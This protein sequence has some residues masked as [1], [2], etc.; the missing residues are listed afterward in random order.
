MCKII[1]KK[2]LYLAQYIGF[3]K[4]SIGKHHYSPHVANGSDNAELNHQMGSYF[5]YYR[6]LEEK[7]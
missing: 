7:N 6:H 2:Q 3:F 4:Y 1:W 5:F